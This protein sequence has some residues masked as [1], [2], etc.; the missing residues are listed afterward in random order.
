MKIYMKLSEYFLE[1][2][3]EALGVLNLCLIA[4]QSKR[5]PHV[6]LN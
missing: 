3:N 1:A 4:C 6:I 2:K 5:D